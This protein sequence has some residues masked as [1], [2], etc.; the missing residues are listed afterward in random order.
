MASS[1]DTETDVGNSRWYC[2]VCEEETE[3]VSEV[4]NR[5][6]LSRP[7][8]VM[9]CVRRGTRLLTTHLYPTLLAQRKTHFDQHKCLKKRYLNQSGLV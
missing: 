9:R 6:S 3:V 2:H 8:L 1:S 4:I 7:M 5:L